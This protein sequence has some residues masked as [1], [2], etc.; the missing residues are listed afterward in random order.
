MYHY[1][2]YGL[3]ISS[4]LELPELLPAQFETADVVISKDQIASDAITDGK[5]LGPFLC[6][7]RTQLLMDVPDV[8]RY[9][10][11]SGNRIT[12]QP[13]GDVDADSIRV[14]LLGSCFGALLFQRGF[15]VLHGNAVQVGGG[16]VIC[17]GHSGAGKSTLAGA[18]VQRGY[19]LLADDVCAINAHGFIEPGFPRIKLW[20]D[21]AKRLGIDTLPLNRIRP[22]IEKFNWPLTDSFCN[23][24]LPVRAVYVLRQHNKDEFVLDEV[25]GMDRFQLLRNY[26]YRP[27][28]MKGMQLQPEHLKL[29]SALAQRTRIARITRPQAGFQLDA[30]IDTLLG[31]LAAQGIYERAGAA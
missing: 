7:D 23:R 19:S 10:I 26:S 28:F 14:F 8:A 11:K 31:D 9:L 13:L 5:Q 12:Y 15:L 22:E 2:C 21:T 27:R 4:D 24:S 1:R 20:A 18:L 3:S 29:C 6:A 25:G 17:V 16:C 30:L